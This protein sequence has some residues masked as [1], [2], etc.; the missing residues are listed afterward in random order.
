MAYAYDVF[1]SYKRGTVNSKWLVEHF[2]PLFKDRLGEQVADKCDRDADGIFFDEDDVKVG[3]KISTRVADGIRSSRCVVALW[4]PR[5]FRSEYCN[6]EWLSFEKRSKEYGKDLVVPAI[7]CQGAN[8]PKEAQD[9]KWIDLSTYTII[10]QG[11]TLSER[12]VEFQDAIARFAKRVAEIV[13]S[14]PEWSE[15]PV[16][17]PPPSPP[18]VTPIM[19]VSL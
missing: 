8:L 5:Y 4:S 15:F 11:F 3:S 13:A 9:R 2:L 18:S 10:G 19:Q 12:Y 1:L 17:D 14:A 16:S 7:I 6:I